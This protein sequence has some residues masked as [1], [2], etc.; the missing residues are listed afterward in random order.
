MA[1][2]NYS[3]VTPSR[4]HM[5][6]LDYASVITKSTPEKSLVKGKNATGGRNN[7]GRITSRFRGAGNKRRYRL[8]DFSR[9]KE[10]VPAKVQA[11]EYDPNRTA[12]LALI[13][14][15]DGEKAYIVAPTGLKVGA[16][17]R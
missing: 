10:N 12:N 1:G 4:R 14:Y 5:A 11:I 13:Q 17:I 7:Y 8:V 16:T 2:K 3:P 6:V 9:A 15:E